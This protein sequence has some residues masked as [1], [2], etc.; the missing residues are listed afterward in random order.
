MLL[1]SKLFHHIWGCYI[2]ELL[3]FLI[4]GIQAGFCFI[5]IFS[6]CFVF[7]HSNSISGDVIYGHVLYPSFMLL[8]LVS[9]SLLLL[10]SCSLFPNSY[11]ISGY[12]ISGNFY[13]SLSKVSRLVSFH[14][15]YY[16]YV[17]YLHIRT[18]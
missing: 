2:W 4:Q 15:N 11:I 12:V 7:S 18:S 14:Y 10:S 1:I 8:I 16:H 17:S 6:L 13:V 9:V 3:C 5:I